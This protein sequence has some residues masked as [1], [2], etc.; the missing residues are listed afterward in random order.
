MFL[1]E[2]RDT[3]KD[4]LKRVLALLVKSKL[5]NGKIDRLS[6]S[7]KFPEKGSIQYKKLNQKRNEL[8][9]RLLQKGD[10]TINIKENGKTISYVLGKDR[11]GLD[12]IETDKVNKLKL[13]S[14]DFSKN[15]IVKYSDDSNEIETQPN[16]QISNSTNII[17]YPGKDTD[18]YLGNDTENI[19]KYNDFGKNDNNKN[20]NIDKNDDEISNLLPSVKNPN[21]KKFGFIPEK[22]YD[23]NDIVNIITSNAKFKSVYMGVIGNDVTNN[24]GNILDNINSE[25]EKSNPLDGVF[26]LFTD[27]LPLS[28][29]KKGIRIFLINE[30]EVGG[31]K[32]IIKSYTNNGNFITKYK[33]KI[34][35]IDLEKKRPMPKRV[36]ESLKISNSSLLEKINSREFQNFINMKINETLLFENFNTDIDFDEIN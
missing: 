3:T 19:I 18:K 22:K 36:I 20:D 16:Y 12:K 26:V 15:N 14:T 35:S 9:K 24:G 23:M 21:N 28:F 4:E 2:E 7:A 10:R 8:E 33:V 25:F 1:N 27:N 31:E 34:L 6:K 5:S 32:Q 17:K 29:I 13:L 11:Y 30:N